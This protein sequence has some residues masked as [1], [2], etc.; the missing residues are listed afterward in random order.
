M[1]PDMPSVRLVLFLFS[2]WPPLAQRSQGLAGLADF[3]CRRAAGGGLSP[4]Q[5]VHRWCPELP[6][7]LNALLLLQGRPAWRAAW[8]ATGHKPSLQSH[9]YLW[10]AGVP[11]SSA[12]VLW[13]IPL[14]RPLMESHF[15][16]P[17]GQLCGREQGPPFLG[18]SRVLGASTSLSGQSGASVARAA[19][20]VDRAQVL[21]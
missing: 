5:A 2:I 12:M 16:S 21:C 9:C 14:W 10:Q 17:S 7:G 11:L 15:W 13:P 18:P 8:E 6:C 20:G 3:S 1:C 19:V 4:S